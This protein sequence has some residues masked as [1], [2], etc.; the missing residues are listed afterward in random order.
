MF[1]SP[2]SGKTHAAQQWTGKQFSQITSL[3]EA[4]NRR[5]N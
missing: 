5:E 3:I 2:L 1:V 4:L